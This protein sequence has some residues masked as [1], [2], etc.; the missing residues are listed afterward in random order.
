MLPRREKRNE[1]SDDVWS[2]FSWSQLIVL[3]QVGDASRSSS[4]LSRHHV[5]LVPPLTVYLFS[6]FRG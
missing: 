5:W 3:T 1:K 4:R 6:G 2:L